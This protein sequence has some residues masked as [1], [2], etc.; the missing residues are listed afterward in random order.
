MN[1]LGIR[2][3]ISLNALVRKVNM[4]LHLRVIEG[5]ILFLIAACLVLLIITAMSPETQKITLVKSEW[6][7]KNEKSVL[8]MQPTGK[9]VVP[10]TDKHCVEYVKKG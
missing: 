7:C 8:R 1:L 9:G 5:V 4:P 3:L 10:I 6:I 2:R